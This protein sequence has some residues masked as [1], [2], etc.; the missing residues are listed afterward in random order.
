M[1]WFGPSAGFNSPAH[2]AFVALCLGVVRLHQQGVPL[3]MTLDPQVSPEK[4]QFEQNPFVKKKDGGDEGAASPS[5]M[6]GKCPLADSWSIHKPEGLGD[7]SWAGK[8]KPVLLPGIC[9]LVHARYKTEQ[10]KHK[11][12]Y[13]L[14]DPVKAFSNPRTPLTSDLWWRLTPRDFMGP[15]KEQEAAQK[16]DQGQRMWREEET[17]ELF[18]DHLCCLPQYRSDEL[19]GAWKANS[20]QHSTTA[21]WSV[22][23][24]SSAGEEQP[25]IS[26]EKT[27]CDKETDWRRFSPKWEALTKL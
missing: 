17:R 16:R 26:T 6:E 24:C 23:S 18:R 10:K 7:Q 11:V 1:V 8:P 15:S 20:L 14:K 27:P 9:E 12:H 22:R 13:I 19:S 25:H 5:V 2:P 21:D 4:Q 3:L